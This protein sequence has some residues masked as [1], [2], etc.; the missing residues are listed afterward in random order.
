MIR[1]KNFILILNNLLKTN[2]GRKNILKIFR[3][4]IVLQIKKNLSRKPFIFK[5][6]SNS[7]AF[8]QKGIE[9]QSISGLFYYGLIELNEVLFSWHILRPNDIFF[10]IGANQGSWGLILCPKKVLCHQFEPSS[11]TFANLKKQISLNEK[12]KD[13][14]IPHKV[15]I[16][17]KNS[18]VSFTKDF[19]TSNHI[20]NEI[21][22][23][24][25]NFEKVESITLNAAAKKYGIP[26]LIKIDVEGF[27]YQVLEKGNKVL[28]NPTLKALIIE[29]FRSQESKKKSFIEFEELLASYGFYP[30]SYNPI[31]RTIKP[32]TK[33]NDCSSNDTI[34][35][36]VS[37]DDLILLK[38]SKPLKVLGEYY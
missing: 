16:S 12:F 4:F 34:Y 33:K 1:I 25:I 3:K 37:R 22:N 5:T 11:E 14:L 10:D 6:C 38:E 27:N 13:Y 28:E 23:K 26:T 32:I 7:F 20:T 15:A 2:F 31:M 21:K 36:R 19:F 35:F 30:Y 24:D 8:V 17:N 18:I 29:T 9:S